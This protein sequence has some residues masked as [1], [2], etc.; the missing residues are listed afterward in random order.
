MIYQGII[1]SLVSMLQHD[2]GIFHGIYEL[3]VNVILKLQ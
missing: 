2:T 1:H 3:L